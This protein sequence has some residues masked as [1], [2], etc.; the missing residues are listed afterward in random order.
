MRGGGKGGD[1]PSGSSSSF[2]WPVRP[3]AGSLLHRRPAAKTQPGHTHRHHNATAFTDAARHN[4]GTPTG[5]TT[6]LPSPMLQDTTRAHPQAPQRH[7]LHRCCKTQPG[8]THRHHNA[9]AFTDAARH[10]QG[11]PTGTTTPLPSPMLQ[12]TTRAHPQAPQRHCLHPC[13]KTGQ[14]EVRGAASKS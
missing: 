13:C 3:L 4:Q 6:P 11:T 12:D 5:T 8:H 7:C 1:G 14:H 9:T 2:R 10:N